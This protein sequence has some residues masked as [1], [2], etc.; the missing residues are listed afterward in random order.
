MSSSPRLR[1]FQRYGVELEYMI[2]DRQNL[3]VKPITDQVLRQVLGHYGSEVERGE[4]FWSNELVLHVIELKCYP[5]AADFVVL[6]E[7]FQKNI[8]EINTLLAAFD[9]QLMPTAAHPWMNP[10]QQTKLWP[11]DN[12]EIYAAYNRIFDCKGHGWSNLQSTHINL[13]FDGDEEFAR[14]HAAIRLVLPILPALAASSP[15]FDQQFTGYLDK[16]LDYYQA[17]QQKIPCLTGKVI[18][19]P[20]FSEESYRQEIYEPIRQAIAPHDPDQILE[21]VWLNSRGAI[22]RFDRGAIEIRVLD[23]QECPAADLAILSLVIS[24]LKMLADEKHITLG[25]QKTWEV[26][27]LYDLFNQ[28]IRKGEEAI[29]ENVAYLQCFG[30]EQKKPVTA[31]ELWQHI[32][33]QSLQWYADELQPWQAQLEIILQ[34]G[35]L[36][37]RI[38]QALDGN[39]KPENLKIVYS[40]LCE[41]LQ[42]N[43][44][45]VP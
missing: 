22:A 10:Y 20:V 8:A 30:L 41:C 15:V 17:N 11:H 40:R 23:I 2:V 12:G 7:Q 33:Q 3:S 44:M 34:Q 18:P 29:I 32:Y 37:R 19:E 43:K 1:I 35:T 13:P 5:P 28:V 31:G 38:L 16:R 9:A 39:Y 14:L 42:Q 24:A 27:P 4:I 6:N 21:P 26:T 45:F 36:S 25:Q